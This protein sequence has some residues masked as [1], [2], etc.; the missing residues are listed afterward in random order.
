MLDYNSQKQQLM[1]LLE[2]YSGNGVAYCDMFADFLLVSG[3]IVLPCNIGDK[4][5]IVGGRY[6]GG[7]YEKWINTG[8]F[9]VR[10]IDKIG[11]SIFLSREEAEKAFEKLQ[12]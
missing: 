5:Y 1:K 9:R 7:Q 8:H 10:D 11:I 6:F 2:E 12:P 4:V 3:V